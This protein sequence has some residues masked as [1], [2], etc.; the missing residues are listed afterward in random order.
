MDAY[1]Q[2]M[3]I[4]QQSQL[5]TPLAHEALLALQMRR[6]RQLDGMAADK[7]HAV[8]ASVIQ[9]GVHELIRQVLKDHRV[10]AE[11]KQLLVQMMR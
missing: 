11:E 9:K 7:K 2:V 3:Q 8:L 10:S 5:A 6:E 4:G 1:A